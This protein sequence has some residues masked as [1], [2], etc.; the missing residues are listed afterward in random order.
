MAHADND[1]VQT[2]LEANNHRIVALQ[3]QNNALVLQNESS[4][5]SSNRLIR[6]ADE[7]IAQLN[8][9][10]QEGKNVM[11]SLQELL[12]REFQ[13]L[14][15]RTQDPPSNGQDEVVARLTRQVEELTIAKE[16]LF[17]KAATISA[18]YDAGELVRSHGL[19]S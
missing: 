2:R 10:V 9:E 14:R 19:S 7:N 18:R 5:T 11:K 13:A 15:S 8:N 4:L 17:M 16:D 12:G 6:A 1:P 3:E